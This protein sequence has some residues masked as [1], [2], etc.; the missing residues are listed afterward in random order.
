VPAGIGLDCVELATANSLR[1]MTSVAMVVEHYSV[2]T[3]LGSRIFLL[4]AMY[5]ADA[6]VLRRLWMSLCESFKGSTRD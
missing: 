5:S 4:E 6:K 2:W 1:V 3:R